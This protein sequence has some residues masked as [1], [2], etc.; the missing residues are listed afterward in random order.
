MQSLAM[1]ITNDSGLAADAVHDTFVEVW[2]NAGRFRP[3][4]GNP[5][6]WL[7]GIVRFR[8]I[9]IRRLRARETLVRD[10]PDQEDKEP[11]ALACLVGVVE[12]ETLHRCLD[13][14]GAKR[15]QMLICAY[16]EGLTHRE[17]ASKYDLPIGTV[18][19][20]VRRALAQLKDEL[21]REET[22][23]VRTGG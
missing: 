5:G 10:I 20:W 23:S 22:C 14:L 15:R 12:A 1:H 8:A 3:E 13:L 6:A 16:V 18:K 2:R 19:S 17:I 21:T 7:T 11:N 9:D 4:R